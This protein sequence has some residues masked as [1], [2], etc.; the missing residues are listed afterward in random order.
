MMFE[1]FH[2]D[3]YRKKFRENKGVKTDGI[4]G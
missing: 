2:L 4:M 1:A 3:L